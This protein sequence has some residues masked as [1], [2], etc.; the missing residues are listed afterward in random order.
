[1]SAPSEPEPASPW[2]AA[3][4][5]AG[6]FLN[7]LFLDFVATFYTNFEYVWLLALRLTLYAAFLC[8]GVIYFPLQL[9][10]RFNGG[11]DEGIAFAL[12]NGMAWAV[13][14]LLIPI[15]ASVWFVTLASFATSTLDTAL[16]TARTGAAHWPNWRVL[17]SIIWLLL[18]APAASG[19]LVRLAQ[20][21][22]FVVKVSVVL[23]FGLALSTAR[24]V[25][26]AIERIREWEGSAPS[27]E[28][29]L[30]FWVVPP[31]VACSPLIRTVLAD[32]RTIRKVLMWGVAIPFLFAVWAALSTMA[33]ASVLENGFRKIPLYSHY[34]GARFNKLGWVKLL[35][36]TFTLLTASRLAANVVTHALVR[37]G[38]IVA[39]TTVTAALLVLLLP[40]IDRFG[41]L[42]PG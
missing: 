41:T 14:N 5:L 22:L 39:G 42:S 1:M 29:A 13:R 19:S 28:P 6:V 15:W 9:G 11:V 34:A 17:L 12:G 40:V 2:S 4:L 8:F 30:L 26:E 24:Y 27:L 7:A 21:S 33:G 18:I 32:R 37:R 38:G 35:L 23:I 20:S 31:L 3:A 36:L 16:L 25:P 10:E